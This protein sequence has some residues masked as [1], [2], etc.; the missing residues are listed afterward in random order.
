[1]NLST[2]VP[3]FIVIGLDRLHAKCLYIGEATLRSRSA[4]KAG[5]GTPRIEN[6]SMINPKS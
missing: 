3:R 5:A 1:L 2:S 4:D 6:S